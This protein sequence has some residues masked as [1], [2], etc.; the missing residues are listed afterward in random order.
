MGLLL[1]RTLYVAASFAVA[2]LAACSDGPT[3][4]DAALPSE[5]ALTVG[6]LHC[7]G[8]VERVEIDCAEPGKADGV[9]RNRLVGGQGTYVRVTSAAP[10]YAGGVFTFSVTVQNLSQLPMATSDGTTRHADGVRLFFHAGP[11]AVS[12][13]GVLAVANAS[14]SATF[15]AANQPYFQLGGS[16]AGSTPTALGADGILSPGEVSAAQTWRLSVPPTVSSFDFTVYVATETQTGALR[17]IAPQVTAISP[18]TLVPGRSATLAGV[19]F[20]ATAAASTVTVG[21]VPAAVTAGSATALTIMVPC[22]PSGSRAVQVS[23][24]GRAGVPVAHPVSVANAFALAVGQSAIVADTPAAA[25]SQLAPSADAIYVAAVYSVSTRSADTAQFR[26]AGDGGAPEGLPAALSREPAQAAGPA[27]PLDVQLRLT[28]Q[29]EEDRAHAAVL[30]RGAAEFRRL[31]ARAAPDAAPG[32]RGQAAA[33]LVAPPAARTFRV[34]NIAL[35]SGACDS[36]YTVN[37]TLVYLSGKLAIYEDNALPAALRASGNPT[38]AEVYRRTGDQFNADMEPIL[39]AN[40]GDV[41]RRDAALDNNGV[42]IALVTPVVNTRFPSVAGFV[43]ACDLFANGPGNGA[44]NV[45]EIFYARAPASTATGY[46]FGTVGEWYWSMRTTFIHEAKHLAS[47]VARVS[48]GAP[49]LETA[50]LE[51]STARHAE[52]LWAR[53]QVY[54]VAWK[55]NTGYGSAKAPGNVYCDLLQTTPACNATNVR[56]PSLNLLPHFDALYAYAANS[57]TYSPFGA[58]PADGAATWYGSGWSLVRYTIDRFGASDAAFLTALNQSRDTSMVNLAARAGRPA[59]EL[60]GR[61]HLSLFTDDWPVSAVAGSRDLQIATWNLPNI[62][63]GLHEQLPGSHPREQPLQTTPLEFGPRVAMNPGA[64]NG[65]GAVYYYFTGN[66]TQAQVLRLTNP[67]G[68]RP[69][70]SLRVAIARVR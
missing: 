70:A 4:R 33:A 8:S 52:E 54:G 28:R 36:W 53:N 42:L 3:A 38:L 55:G 6:A 30:E 66:R 44:S 23:T 26:V 25:C 65:G 2:L 27:L 40:F 61:W 11:T 15:T 48:N 18:A 16:G 39:R 19:N 31:R 57:R 64:V 49:T 60:Q 56:R 35:T 1:S 68:G 63:A 69:A 34:P 20:G 17:S 10:A 22:V 5:P 41:L 32:A 43:I 9:L 24:A 21:G 29:R 46:G 67:A 58:T 13:S 14:G 50:W 37:A 7:S 51:E 62:F 12:G 45:G 47:N 59:A